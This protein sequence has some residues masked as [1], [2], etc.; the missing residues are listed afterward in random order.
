MY[1][2]KFKDGI[3]NMDRVLH[4]DKVLTKEPHS[5]SEGNEF[6]YRVTFINGDYWDIT[7]AGFE[8]IIS[9][10]NQIGKINRGGG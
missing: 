1:Y 7:R 2:I 5:D 9:V 4:I 10:L 8:D 6:C 3:L